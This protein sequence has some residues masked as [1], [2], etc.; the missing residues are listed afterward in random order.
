MTDKRHVLVAITDKST[1][2]L[3]V[4]SLVGSVG[5]EVHSVRDYDSAL[6]KIADLPEA[7][8]V[9]ATPLIWRDSVYNRNVCASDMLNRALEQNQRVRLI[10]EVYAEDLEGGVGAVFSG[11]N[12]SLITLLDKPGVQIADKGIFSSF[13]T[14]T[15]QIYDFIEGIPTRFSIY[16]AA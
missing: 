1:N 7:S 3:V 13:D 11:F 15:S 10:S 12:P 14:T 5:M 16:E 8:V 9:I 6:R 2:N 4:Q